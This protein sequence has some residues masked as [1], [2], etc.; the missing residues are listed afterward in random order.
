MKYVISILFIVAIASIITGFVIKPN[1]AADKYIGIGV[2]ALFFVVIPLF[3]YHRWKGRKMSDY[4][5]NK[6][7]IQK[8]R[9]Y[10][11]EKEN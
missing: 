7:N 11:D 4:V 9:D 10:Q 5:L 3:T 1:P 8:M 2:A 6:E